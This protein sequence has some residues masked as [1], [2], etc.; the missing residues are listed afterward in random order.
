MKAFDD[1]HKNLYI[2]YITTM[3]FP[4]LARHTAHSLQTNKKKQTNKQT[5]KNK[6]NCSGPNKFLKKLEN[7]EFWPPPINIT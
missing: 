5:K 7:H 6:Y 2:R 1:E 4:K 3:S